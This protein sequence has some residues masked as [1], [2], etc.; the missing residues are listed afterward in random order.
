MPAQFPYRFISSSVSTSRSR[1]RV[2]PTSW[3]A[4]I[5]SDNC[6]MELFVL[7]RLCH[8]PCHQPDDR[9]RRQVL[10]SALVLEVAK[11]LGDPSN[12]KSSNNAEAEKVA[13]AGDDHLGTSVILRAASVEG[14]APLSLASAF[15]PA[16]F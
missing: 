14:V 1:T 5:H 12:G 11:K 15:A 6:C 9:R 16:R 8:R 3:S 10:A 7:G 13:V 2:P 4:A